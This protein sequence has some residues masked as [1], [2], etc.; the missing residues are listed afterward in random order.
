M[1]YDECRRQYPE[2]H[3]ER[4][5][6]DETADRINLTYTFTIPGLDTFRPTWSIPKSPR[7]PGRALDDPVVRRMI[8]MLGMVELVSY[9]KITC[10]PTVRIHAGDLDAE[11]VA[12]WK[13][14]YFYGL[15]EFFY[16]NSIPAEEASFMTILSE[17]CA[18]AGNSGE[19]GCPSGGAPLAQEGKSMPG[20]SPQGAFQDGRNKPWPLD[21]C[22]IPI[23]GGKDSAVTL[24]LLRSRKATNACFIIN[25]RGATL[26]TARVAGYSGGSVLT[27]T[28]TLD[29][30][31]LERNRQ[32]FL[33]GHTPFSAL[34]AFSSVLTAYLNGK[35]FV[36]LSNES[37]ANESTVQGSEV[38]HQYSKSVQFEEDFIRYERKYIGSGVSYFSLLRPWSEFQIARYFSKLKPYHAVF[39]SCNAGSKQD[40]WCGKCPKCLFVYL[41][42][43]PFLTTEELTGIFGRNL[44]EDESLLPL[45]EKLTGLLPEKPFECVGSREEVNTAI[46]MTID[47]MQREG[48]AIP[49]LLRDYMGRPL[50]EYY[51]NRGNPYD[52]YFETHHFLPAEFER[53]MRDASRPAEG[54]EVC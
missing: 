38:N 39:R 20:D 15:G 53:L 22:L 34:V 10:S 23:G 41:I 14:Q 4:A 21:G 31:M 37:S 49:P 12:W 51:R 13:K 35:R 27:L 16:V 1:T 5:Q 30:A 26:E 47:R 18:S 7:F 11:S 42:L 43:S 17:G 29:P 45:L 50:Y 8:F 33:N 32:G 44:L 28:R 52:H 2:F 54:D 36:V 3:Y 6:A 48:E 46:C 9:W 25:P 40:I 19:A 24:E